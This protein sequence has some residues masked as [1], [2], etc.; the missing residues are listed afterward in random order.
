MNRSFTVY[1]RDK[2]TFKKE[3]KKER[4]KEY[5]GVKGKN[6]SKQA[7]MKERKKERIFRTEG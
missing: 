6:K 3:R 1:G 5:L 2:K 7:S 4:K